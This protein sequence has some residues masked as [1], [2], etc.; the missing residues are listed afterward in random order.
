MSHTLQFRRQFV[1]TCAQNWSSL[2]EP[3]FAGEGEAAFRSQIPTFRLS[4]SL[5]VAVFQLYFNLLQQIAY[6]LTQVAGIC[7]AMLIIQ[8]KQSKMNKNEKKLYFLKQS[9]LHVFPIYL[10]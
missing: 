5:I 1:L 8:F 10:P 4:E 3:C 7:N 2:D 6:L 9:I